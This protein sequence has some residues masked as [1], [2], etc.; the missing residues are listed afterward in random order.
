VSGSCRNWGA[1]SKDGVILFSPGIQD[2]LFRVDSAGGVPTPV[3]S[4]DFRN[5]EETHRFPSFLPNGRHF[6]FYIRAARPGVS[7]VY[8]G[9]FD[10]TPPKKILTTESA[11]I[12]APPNHLLFSR[13]G[14]LLDADVDAAAGG[15]VGEPRAIISGLST[16]LRLRW[17]RFSVSERGTL[18]FDSSPVALTEREMFWVDRQGRS[19]RLAGKIVNSRHLS[20]SASG[21]RV[22]YDYPDPTTGSDFG[23]GSSARRQHTGG[24][25][26]WERRRSRP[27][28]GR[29][30]DCLPFD[31]A[32]KSL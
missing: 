10:G 17:G 8:F 14:S 15:I 16:N 25:A 21:M 28:E 30:T 23:S 22:A 26:A 27:L 31:C 3:T 4:L 11:A 12:V 5:G 9:S 6:V 29:E 32:R 13:N 20:L 24:N 2:P 7:G 19:L 18:V 1:W